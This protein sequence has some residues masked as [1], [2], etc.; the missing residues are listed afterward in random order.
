MRTV[1]PD[2]VPKLPELN[3]EHTF[4]DVGLHVVRGPAPPG[5]FPRGEILA[6]E[7][8]GFVWHRSVAESHHRVLAGPGFPD[9]LAYANAGT[10]C[11]PFRRVPRFRTSSHS[12]LE[13]VA[14]ALRKIGK[15]RYPGR[16]IVL[17][18]Q[19][20][21]HLIERTFDE[22]MWLF[23]DE[24]AVEPSLHPSSARRSEIDSRSAALWSFLVQIHLAR[25]KGLRVNAG[26]DLI[27]GDLYYDRGQL[28]ALAFAQHYGLP[29]PAL[30]VTTDLEIALW[31]ASHRLL[32]ADMNLLRHE[33]AHH[34]EAVIYVIAVEEGQYFDH[35]ITPGAIRPGRQRG[36]FLASNWGLSRNR[37]A[38]SLVGAL[39][40]PPELADQLGPRLP[41]AGSLF[42]GPTE[43][44]FV[45]TLLTLRSRQADLPSLSRILDLVY[46]VEEGMGKPDFLTD[47]SIPTPRTP[48]DWNNAGVALSSLGRPFSAE[49][50][51]RVAAEGGSAFGACNLGQRF[52]R[53]GLL[54]EAETWLARISDHDP[55]AANDLSYVLRWRGR[56][57]E[58][59]INVLIPF[60]DQHSTCAFSLAQ[61]L[62]EVGRPDDAALRF[63]R[64]A[65]LGDPDAK[66]WLATHRK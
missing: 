42:P 24:G 50:C 35:T 16:R 12:E 8:Y 26:G 14:L 65:Q 41:S 4:N 47:G 9:A 62:I 46:W 43:D 3:A 51:F 37:A 20:K 54:A 60:A 53:R 10:L 33:K 40:F 34:P 58:E 57:V 59:S 31:F 1:D 38:R 2:D 61:L 7:E 44:P 17:R 19:T 39:Y 28:L 23:G 63:E 49:R 21:E 36:G 32:H 64:A 15:E 48:D 52:L 13:E 30:D 18:G 6:D 66:E 55:D 56:P 27:Q 22:K 45:E 5:L 29:T 11:V 25:L